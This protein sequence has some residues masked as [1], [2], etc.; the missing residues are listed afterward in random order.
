MLQVNPQAG[1]EW[2]IKRKQ[3]KTPEKDWCPDVPGY[4][5]TFDVCSLHAMESY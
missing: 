5:A 1:G 4:L 2:E 3:D